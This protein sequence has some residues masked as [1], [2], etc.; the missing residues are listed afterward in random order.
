MS[1]HILDVKRVLAVGAHPDDIEIGCLGLLLKLS[2]GVE[3]HLY[4]ASFGSAGDPTSGPARR[5]ESE[6]ACSCLQPAS[7]VFREAAGILPSD[8]VEIMTDLTR[9]LDRCRP[10]LVLV[11]SL[12][13]SH[14]EHSYVYHAAVSALRRSGASLVAYCG[15]STTLDFR[16]TL[17]VDITAVVETKMQA[18]AKHRS[19]QSKGYLTR[20]FFDVFHTHPYAVV[21]GIHCCERF[22]P[23]RLFW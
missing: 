18:L 3:K 23:V 7:I 8:H 11:G 21:N 10:D 15:N 9:L 5:V 1:G 19:Q 16:P 22:E 17:F 6:A 4:I 14:Q 12:H 20:E 13:D 2:A